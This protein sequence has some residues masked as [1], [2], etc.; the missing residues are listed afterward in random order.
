M[1]RYSS[2]K[3]TRDPEE[4]AGTTYLEMAQDLAAREDLPHASKRTYR[5]ALMWQIRAKPST[6]DQDAEA[7]A[8]LD[9]LIRTPGPKPKSTKAKT[10]PEEDMNLLLE[11]LAGMGMGMRSR[12]AYRAHFWIIAGLAT[13][14]RPGMQPGQDTEHQDQLRYRGRTTRIRL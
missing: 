1:Q 6:P 14:L 2:A 11:E 7:L 5:A 13:G 10:I 8:V 9:A 12:W 4:P 3:R